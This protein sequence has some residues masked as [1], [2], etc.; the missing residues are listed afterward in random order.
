M[1]KQPKHLMPPYQVRGRLWIGPAKD[2][3]MQALAQLVTHIPNKGEQM[4]RYY[5]TQINR[6]DYGKRQVPMI[7]FRRL[8][9]LRFRPKSS[10]KIGLG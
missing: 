1:L 9:N 2:G 5:S 8:L 3:G 4:V 6:V 10:A 7:K